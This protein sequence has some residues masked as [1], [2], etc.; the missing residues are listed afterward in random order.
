M[1]ILLE[2]HQLTPR[3]IDNEHTKIILITQLFNNQNI[4]EVVFVRGGSLSF[5]FSL[6]GRSVL[7]PGIGGVAHFLQ[8]VVSI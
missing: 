3:I 7:T 4:S 2:M 6:G 8:N 5:L 1:E